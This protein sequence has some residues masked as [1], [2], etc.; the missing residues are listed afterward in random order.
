MVY[1][2]SKKMVLI[3][4]LGMMLSIFSVCLQSQN[5]EI[6]YI[7][8]QQGQSILIRGPNGTLILLDG[9]D[10][11]KGN[12]EV[13]PYLESKG[14]YTSTTLN[15]II[16]THLDEDHIAGLTE[17]MD[18]GYNASKVYY[19]GSIKDRTF[20]DNFKSAASGTTAG[21]VTTI[22]LGQIITLG[23]G[24]KATCVA[25]NG[26]ILGGGTVSIPS[27][28]END[29]SIAL[30]IQ[31]GNFDYLVTGDAGGGQSDS[32]CTGRNTSQKNIETPLANAI[33]PGGGNT[34]LTSNGVEV[35][36]VAHHGSESST[37][38]DFMNLLTPTVACISVG[39][40][41]GG[42][43]YHPRKAVVENV[44]MAQAACITA[45]PALVLQTEEGNPTSIDTS[46]AGYCVGD[47]V[48]KTNGQSTFTISASGAVTQG[49][50]EISSAG[51]PVTFNLDDEN[52]CCKPTIL[53]SEVL[54]DSWITGDTEGEWIELYNN[55]SSPVDIGDWTLNDIDK[56]FDI[57]KGTTLAAKGCMVIA[58]GRNVFYQKYGSYPQVEGMNLQLSNTGGF[59]KLKNTKGEVV[60]Q[61]AWE[62]GGSLI[63]GWGSTNFPKAD[64]SKSIRREN[65]TTDTDKYSDWL[66]NQVPN[67]CVEALESQISLSTA[68]IDF[69]FDVGGIESSTFSISNSGSAPLNWSVADDQP[70]LE[71]SPGSGTNS[72]NVEVIVNMTAYPEG[73]YTGTVTVNAPN[74]SN[75]PQKV[76][77]TVYIGVQNPSI[78]LNRNTLTYCARDS[79]CTGL[80]SVL[81]SNSGNGMLY[82]NA[83]SNSS[84]LIVSPSSGTNDGELLIQ[85]NKSGLPLGTFIGTVTVSDVNDGN[86]SQHIT[87]T[88][89]VIQSSD[90]PFGTF[91]T[92]SNGATIRSSIAVTGWV[93]DDIEVESVKIY[94]GSSYVGDAVFVEGA[95]PD[96]ESVYSGYPM[97]YRAGWGYMMLTNF[98]PGGGNG[99]YTFNAKATDKEGNTVTLGSKTVTIDND[100]AVKPFGAIDT[101][102]QGGSA[103]GSSFINWGWVLTPLPNM[104]PIDGS[105]IDVWIDGQN[106]GHPT[107]NLYRSDIAGS[108]PGYVNSNGAVG[109]FYINTNSFPNGV[110]TI[111]WTAKDTGNNKDGIGSRYFTIN[112]TSADIARHKIANVKNHLVPSHHLNIQQ[113]ERLYQMGNRLPVKVQTAFVDD[114]DMQMV[115]PEETGIISLQIKE[116]GRIVIDFSILSQK[117]QVYDIFLNQKPN[118]F[119]GYMVVDNE[120]RSLP[121]G[122]SL[123]RKQ[124][125]FYWQPG[126]GFIGNYEFV[127]L[128]NDDPMV[129]K[130]VN[131]K[132]LPMHHNGKE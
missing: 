100:G 94:N 50:N 114:E 105:T 121:I 1:S 22:T 45:S 102:G 49:P 20:I 72:G 24:A 67:P 14:I 16:A 78:S 98:L 119:S 47:I 52:G 120:L 109:Y 97:N 75:S 93:L 41:Q 110:H 112:N 61:V 85:V 96:V 123:N 5:L 35:L 60:D 101:P 7:N 124:G 18:A 48:I 99:T 108:F 8:V 30:L 111:Q 88:I 107:Y 13:I 29:R 58:D 80:Q 118:S 76:T 9:G 130:K 81:V 59:I 25:S 83:T 90:E 71:L 28:N 43:S 46:Y 116:L 125:I 4:L 10:V 68:K 95:R 57:P 129:F 74:C 53:I 86:S 33:M 89:D 42:T 6:H 104:I 12:N 23:N 113:M 21:G 63:T 31:Y 122:S 2:K 103:S 127:F 56:N 69:Y 115:F 106:Y 73:T 65:L 38:S 19:N 44:L 70:W 39:G 92:P 117:E 36:H 66:S 17:I 79:Y 87:V 34:L 77:I 82:W 26:S 3:L 55:S 131:I 54:Y 32:S 128:I 11:G 62:S 64:E 27:T 37:N 126:P 84:W 91:E 51:L 40:G 132:I 15:Y